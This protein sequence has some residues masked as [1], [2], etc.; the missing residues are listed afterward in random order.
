MM[1]GY[2][3]FISFILFCLFYHTLMLGVTYCWGHMLYLNSCDGIGNGFIHYINVT[4]VV[5]PGVRCY[6]PLLFIVVWF[7]MLWNQWVSVGHHGP[8]VVGCYLNLSSSNLIN[9]LSHICGS[10]YLPISLFRGGSLTLISIASLMVLAMLWSSLPTMLNLS[11]D[12]S[13]P[14]MLWWSWMGDGA[15][16]CSLNLSENVLPDSPI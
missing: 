9:T 8:D 6:C 7:M 15:L 2:L 10:W 4:D 13:W 16:M 5:V 12:N 3:C 11:R 1:C 14:V